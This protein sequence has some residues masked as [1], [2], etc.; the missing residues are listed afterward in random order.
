MARA[1]RGQAAV[2]AELSVIDEETAA[3]AGMSAVDRAYHRISDA[4]LSGSISAGK[5]LTEAAIRDEIGVGRGAFR[6][7]LYRLES[8]G[9]LELHPNRG[10]MVRRLSRQDLA[11]FFQYRV[12]VESYACKRAAQRIDELGCRDR[13]LELFREL[14]GYIEG[15]EA[16]PFVDHNEDFHESLVQ[17]S[18]NRILYSQWKRLRLPML[19]IRRVMEA[20]PPQDRGSVQQHVDILEAVL[21]GRESD[22]EQFMAAHIQ[23]THRFAQRLSDQDFDRVFNP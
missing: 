10:A 16:R 3:D 12:V 15:T 7:A 23:Q 14:R 19:R 4:I 13:A 22:A 17:L 1:L 21:D 18:G 5:H 2:A 8:D 9:F 6:E 11:E 20:W